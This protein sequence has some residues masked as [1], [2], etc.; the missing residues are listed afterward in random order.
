V[1]EII[2]GLSRDDG[3]LKVGDDSEQLLWS[4]AATL[5]ALMIDNRRTLSRWGPYGW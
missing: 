3:V 2:A 4:D 1:R 5:S